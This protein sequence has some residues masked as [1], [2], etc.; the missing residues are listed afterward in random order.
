VAGKL[1]FVVERL[2]VA[3]VLQQVVHSFEPKAGAAG[4]AM[5]TAMTSGLFVLGDAVRLGQAIGNLVSN[6]LKFTE[7]GGRVHVQ[8]RRHE[9]FV[10]VIVRDTGEGI[11]PLTLPHVF[12]LFHQGP[13]ALHRRQGLGLGLTI[14]KHIVELHGGSIAAESA[15]PGQGTTFIVRLPLAP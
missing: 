14:A 7:P 8:A 2:D 11:D 12:G 6:A 4:V 1:D 10:E 13:S 9:Q 5:E 3:A 15:G